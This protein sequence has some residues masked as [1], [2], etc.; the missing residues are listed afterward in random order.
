MATKIGS[1]FG[2]ELAAAGL[3]GVHLSW[4]KTGLTLGSNLTAA[5]LAKVNQV[6]ATHD[7]T[8][9]DLSTSVQV[10][11]TANPSLDGVYA[12]DPASLQKIAQIATGIAARNRLPGGGTAFNYLDAAGNSH[13]FGASDFLNF[14]AAVEDYAYAVGQVL[15]AGGA[16]RAT[17]WPATP[18]Q[19]P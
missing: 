17:T 12:V 3:G 6:L 18:I 13:A 2:N 10:N 9:P 8:K 1:N 11:S 4:S 16:G 19:I 7:A 5:Q 14:A 15:G